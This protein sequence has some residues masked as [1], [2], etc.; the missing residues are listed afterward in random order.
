MASKKK[1]KK[2]LAKKALERTRGGAGFDPVLDLKG[3][4][5]ESELARRS[6]V[7]SIAVTFDTQTTF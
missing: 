6:R 5:G 2:P 4:A 3:I 1:A 7:T